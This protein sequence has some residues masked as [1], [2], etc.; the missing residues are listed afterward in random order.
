MAP[1][2]VPTYD[3]DPSV[4]HPDVADTG[5]SG[6]NGYRY[7]MG[8]TPYPGANRENPSI[9]ASVD[10]VTWSVPA[11]LTNPLVDVSQIQGAGYLWGSDPCLCLAPD[12]AT[13]ELYWRPYKDV[14]GNLEAIY[15]KTSTDGATWTPSGLGTKVL[16]DLVSTDAIVSPTVLATT[17]DNRIMWVVDRS[18]NSLVRRTSTDAGL[19]WSTGTTCT[20]PAGIA[21]WHVQVVERDGTYHALVD[22]L[23]AGSAHHLVYLTSADGLTWT[24]SPMRAVPQSITAYDSSGRHYRSTMVPGTAVGRWH[25]LV[26]GIPV[27]GRTGTTPSV[28]ADQPWRLLLY[29]DLAL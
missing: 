13:L 2:E 14:G 22:A 4:T 26:S 9:L 5:S 6:W 17:G 25:V 7:W 27:N 15:R 23:E 19:T 18:V 21:P 8:I 24:G 16:G 12:R 10:L 29:R 11:G 28:G 20:I 3:G 1:I